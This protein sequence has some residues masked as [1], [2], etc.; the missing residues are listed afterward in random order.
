MHRL[1][2]AVVLALILV[3]AIAPSLTGVELMH[4]VFEVGPRDFVRRELYVDYGSR[5]A[6]I[7]YVYS[8]GY[9]SD[10]IFRIIAPDGREIYP[11][12][13]IERGLSWSFT[14]TQGG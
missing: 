11:R 6:I 14:A 1:L 7:F 8:G 10:I 12:T 13:K 5:V 3:V 2:I 9:P 4:Y